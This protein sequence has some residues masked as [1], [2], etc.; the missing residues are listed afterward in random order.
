M[1]LKQTWFLIGL[2]LAIFKK[3]EEIVGYILRSFKSDLNVSTD[4]NQINEVFP[5]KRCS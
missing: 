2:N 5:W 4:S 3:S 1:L